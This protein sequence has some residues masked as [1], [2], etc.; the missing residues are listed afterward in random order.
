MENKIFSLVYFYILSAVSIKHDK[1]FFKR[2]KKYVE[3]I[4]YI[5][6]NDVKYFW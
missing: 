5:G 3:N 1:Y 4:V 6:P 2:K